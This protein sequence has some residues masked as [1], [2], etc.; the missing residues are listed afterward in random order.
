[1][2]GRKV[3]DQLLERNL[4]DEHVPTNDILSVLKRSLGL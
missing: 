1:M 3:L 4:V 2:M